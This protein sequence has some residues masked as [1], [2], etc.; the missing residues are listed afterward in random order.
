M[1]SVNDRMPRQYARYCDLSIRHVS[2]FDD[3]TCI[4][5][6]ND[7]EENP[8]AARGE[9]L[10]QYREAAG[11]KSASAAARELRLVESTLRSHENGTRSIGDDDARRYAEKF[12]RPVRRITALDIMYGPS[13][14]R[15]E[16]PPTGITLVPVV[17]MVGAGGN[18]EP[19]YEQ[20]P[21][22]GLLQVELPFVVPDE[23]IAFQVDGD[24]MLPKYDDGDVILVWRE[25]KKPI[26]SFYGREAIVRTSDGHRY[27]KTILYGK[28]R[29]VVN[30]Q[31]F[32]AKLIEGVRL[33]WIGEIYSVI[34]GDQIKRLDRL[35]SR[36]S[37]RS[38]SSTPRR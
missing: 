20:V 36:S 25:T 37:Q 14:S 6:R 24:S 32:N 29:A 5:M 16:P 11:F 8:R 7:D 9:R 19:E 4:A 34:R 18:V 10:R 38:P 27:I 28:T 13:S 17:G 26:E 12:S 3:T 1:I 21:A 31:S 30:L 2:N 22:E 15:P 33:E 35:K 23:L